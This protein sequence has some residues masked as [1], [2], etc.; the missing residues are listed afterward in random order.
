MA[1]SQ[2]SVELPGVAGVPRSLSDRPV[3]YRAGVHIWRFV[4]GKPLGALGA[5]LIVL[6]LIAATFTDQLDRY[7][8]NLTFQKSNPAYDPELAQQALLDPNVRLQHPPE[9]FEEGGVLNR[10]GKPS[11]ENWLGTDHLGRDLWSRIIHGSQTAVVVGF[12]ASTIAVA[13]G[14]IIGLASAYFG[15]WVDFGIQRMVDTFQ[16]FPAL[17]L[18]LLFNQVVADPTLY[19]ITLSLGILGIAQVVRIVRSAVLSAREE[20]YVTAAK[21]VGASD[22]RIMARHIFPN[23]TAP[24]IVVFTSTIGVYILAE[25][26]LGFLGLSDPTRP[27]WGKMVEEGRRQGTGEPL[28]ALFVGGALTLTVLG[29]NLAGDALRDVLDPRMRGRGSRAGF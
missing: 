4:T 13:L 24:I 16:A 11:S 28:M 10:L 17:V 25:A 21:T 7:D 2:V 26:T 29:F 15:G 3:F 14:V 18:L 9:V 5:V 27:S 19:W 23:V 8:P 6:V 22:V 20:V 1:Q 12:G